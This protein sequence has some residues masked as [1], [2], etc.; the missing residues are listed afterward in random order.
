MSR[1]FLSVV[2]SFFLLFQATSL[3][4]ENPTEAGAEEM[5]VR[6]AKVPVE[7]ESTEPKGEEE[8]QAKTREEVQ[9]KAKPK[10]TLSEAEKEALAAE[11]AELRE[12]GVAEE[13][14]PE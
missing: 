1:L 12:A 7:V 11:E 3:A 14:I 8:P 10:D 5:E 4:E 13:P 6:E 9:E 2:F